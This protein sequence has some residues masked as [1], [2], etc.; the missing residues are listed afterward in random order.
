MLKYGFLMESSAGL[1]LTRV[2]LLKSVKKSMETYFWKI[3][4]NCEI[5]FNIQKL[6]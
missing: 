3:S 6:I 4:Q 5:T 2:S 1:P